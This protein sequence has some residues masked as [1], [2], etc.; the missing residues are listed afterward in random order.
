MS[1]YFKIVGIVSVI[2]AI[3]GLIVFLFWGIKTQLNPFILIIGFVSIAFFTPAFGLALYVLGGLIEDK[4]ETSI[5]SNVNSDKER[6]KR[7]II[8]SNK[9]NASVKSWNNQEREVV[10]PFIYNGKTITKIENNA[11]MH[12]DYIRSVTIP[13]SITHIGISAFLGCSSLEFII[14]PD[15]VSNIG[16]AAFL[17][18]ES[19]KTIYYTGRKEQWNNISI[20]KF[21][22][23]L[24]N[25]EII[26][27][28]IEEN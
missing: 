25:A 20:A 13:N 7:I 3:L 9:S 8:S 5:I 1:K 2:D 10:I 6:E 22:D 19:L 28:Y 15:S 12:C 16:E 4:Q 17:S 14:I 26:Y 24:T 18:C 23:T 21:N 27:N 11:F